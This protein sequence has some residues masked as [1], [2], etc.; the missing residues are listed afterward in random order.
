MVKQS[1]A[2]VINTPR[3]KAIKSFED[4]IF[5]CEWLW[6]TANEKILASN[7]YRLAIYLLVSRNNLTSDDNG[8]VSEFFLK[9][10]NIYEYEWS[11]Y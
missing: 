8:K 5:Y 1:M 10:V 4:I 6:V 9:Y 2:K 7:N 11:N 3:F